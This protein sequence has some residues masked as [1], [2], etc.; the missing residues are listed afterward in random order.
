MFEILIHSW[1]VGDMRP[2]QNSLRVVEILVKWDDTKYL[3]TLLNHWW[4]EVCKCFSNSEI[5]SKS[6]NLFEFWQVCIFVGHARPAG[7][8]LFDMCHSS[9]RALWKIEFS[10]MYLVAGL[11]CCCLSIPISHVASFCVWWEACFT[12][13]STRSSTCV[14]LNFCTLSTLWVEGC[15]H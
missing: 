10:C 15:M 6:S 11:S 4:N 12:A 13:L 5:C 2:C 14:P 7:R 9:V 8:S 1:N 3:Y